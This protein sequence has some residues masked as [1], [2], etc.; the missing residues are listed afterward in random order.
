[1]VCGCV[2]VV[3]CP[4]HPYLSK[5]MVRNMDVVANCNWDGEEEGARAATCTHDLGCVV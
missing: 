4:S 3:C 5:P 1:M 2:R